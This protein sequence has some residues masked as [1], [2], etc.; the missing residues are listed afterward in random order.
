MLT[1][2]FRKK[3]VV[4]ALPAILIVLFLVLSTLLVGAVND[5]GLN[6]TANAAG[7]PTNISLP[8][9][10]GN[11]AGAALAIA[12]SLFLF[13]MV[14]GGILILTSAGKEAQVKK[15]KDVITWAIIG[16]IILGAAYAITTLVFTA[17]SGGK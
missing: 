7:V 15:G 1:K 17:I 2:Y 11:I 4:F 9:F 8:E 13:L 14:Y 16:A 3:I 10:L 6:T 12:G 5:G